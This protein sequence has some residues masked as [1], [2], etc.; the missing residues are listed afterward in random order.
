MTKRRIENSPINIHMTRV[1]C[2]VGYTRSIIYS[3]NELISHLVLKYKE[4]LFLE[5]TTGKEITL[6]Y[7]FY[8]FIFIS[9]IIL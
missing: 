6:N 4:V 7:S 9:D 8:F 1:I 5:K 3:L 2:E